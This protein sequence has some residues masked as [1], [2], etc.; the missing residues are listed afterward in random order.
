MSSIF[1]ASRTA[2]IPNKFLDIDDTKTAYIHVMLYDFRSGAVDGGRADVYGFRR[3]R[4]QLGDGHANEIERG[5]A[6][7]DA[8]L[9]HDHDATP[10]TSMSTP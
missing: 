2:E 5:F 3:C 9:A 10:S 8:R 4:R 1:L 7:A 6:L